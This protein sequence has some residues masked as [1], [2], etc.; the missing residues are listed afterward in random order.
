MPSDRYDEVD[1]QLAHA[2]QI[3]GRVPFSLVADVLGVSDKT[4]ARRYS[5]LRTLGAIRVIADCSIFTTGQSAWMLRI[6]CSPASAESVA[7]ALARRADSS[8]IALTSGGADLVGVAQN[9]E[10]ADTADLLGRI[11]ATAGVEAV[12]AQRLL[13]GFA[14]E[15]ITFMAKHGPLTAAQVAALRA[16]P[17]TTADGTTLGTEGVAPVVLTADDQCLLD[18]LA[19]DA[20]RDAD[21]LAADTGWSASTVR[22]RIARL[23][24]DRVLRFGLELD[25]RMFGLNTRAALW[26]SVSPT[27]LEA[28]GAELAAHPEITGASA[29][30]GPTNLYASALVAD[31]Q[32]LYRYLT[33]A[34]AA[35][36]GL[37]QIES[38]PLLRVV[39]LSRGAPGYSPP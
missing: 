9:F 16:E 32:A 27:R 1:R 36:S 15:P 2:L 14:S 33:G 17:D 24:A 4:I 7:T 13:H 34:L 31:E 22:R 26:L 25:W 20:R 39:K 10:D 37:T 30:T 18:A 8:Y 11:R 29:T 38:A 21:S 28:A 3:D 12:T 23:R 5:R 35:V 19:V 6:R